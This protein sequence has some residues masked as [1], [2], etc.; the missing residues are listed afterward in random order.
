MS[1]EAGDAP[2]GEAARRG[3]VGAGFDELLAHYLT[4]VESEGLGALD[5]LGSHHP[6]HAAVLRERIQALSDAGLLGSSAEPA[7]LPERI[8]PY[9]ILDRLGSG[10][11][12]IVYRARDEE[13]GRD[14]ALKLARPELVLYPG[15]IERFQ[16]E[17]RAIARLQ[18]AHIVTL[19]AFGEAAGVP[20]F[21]M[22][23]VLGASLADVLSAL[24]GRR[25]A[26][27]TGA[28]L[29]SA[30]LACAREHGMEEHEIRAV[31]GAGAPQLFA[32]SWAEVALRIA[33]A[34]A[35]ALEHAHQA[36][37]LHRDVKPSN[38]LLALDGRVLLSDFGLAG[39]EG[40]STLTRSSAQI[41][42]LPYLP[43]ERLDGARPARSSDVYSLGVTLYETLTLEAAFLGADESVTRRSIQ[44]AS[45][46]PPR[47]R[48]PALARDVETL[49]SVAMAPEPERR[50]ASAA[51]LARDIGNVFAKRPLEA[52]RARVLLR[53]RRWLARH[54]RVAV[55]LSLGTLAL[56]IGPTTWAIQERRAGRAIQAQKD[57]LAALNVQLGAALDR[58]RRE[59]RR[60]GDFSA[61]ALDAIERMLLHVGDVGLE[62]VPQAEGVR[63]AALEDALALC[64]ELGALEPA[65]D[66]TQRLQAR[67]LRSKGDLLALVG[68]GD[69]AL[70]AWNA[71][72]V[73]FRRLLAQDASDLEAR[74]EVAAALGSKGRFLQDVRGEPDAAIPCLEEASALEL[75]LVREH[76]DDLDVARRAA[77]TLRNLGVACA[78]DGQTAR[79]RHVYARALDHA[80]GL[81]GADAADHRAHYLCGLLLHAQADLAREAGAT[82][83]AIEG[84]R[85]ALGSIEEAQRLAPTVPHYRG[86]RMLVHGS[87]AEARLTSG[88]APGALEG[89]EIALEIARALRHDFPAVPW[90]QD[91]SAEAHSACARAARAAGDPVLAAEHARQACAEMRELVERVPDSTGYARAL[92]RCLSE[93]AESERRLGNLEQARAA[94]AEAAERSSVVER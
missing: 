37:I 62:G 67:V 69:E 71:H 34:I 40:T 70:A 76:G 74:S 75:A 64:A 12:A 22:E 47:E 11:M 83:E 94:D 58:A 46:V 27:L 16:R 91:A 49:L 92:V 15:V 2:P 79:A 50:Y 28:D 89:A 21:A 33:Q 52:Q 43:P 45:P 87:L 10:G 5:E 77:S 14:V 42:S 23:R 29:H 66:A 80:R 61:K 18:H 8:G 90:Y 88:D 51:A 17:A 24:A 60:A 54:P 86:G 68:R 65:G 59:E 9:R 82:A 30:L 48:N 57:E 81:V 25:P 20:Y 36:G 3:R 38:V 32:G 26:E 72:L 39:V 78:F 6:E 84:Y 56:V 53:A 35:H 73:T 13:L 93:L 55:A 7:R 44:L 63:V 1:C 41:G 19:Y 4:R 31:A 85:A